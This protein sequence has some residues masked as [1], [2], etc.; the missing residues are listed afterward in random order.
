MASKTLLGPE[1][2]EG[3]IVLKAAADAKPV[4]KQLLP[5]IGNVSVTFALKIGYAG[6]PLLVTVLPKP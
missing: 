5:V 1:Q 2:S 6:E 4:E 3:L